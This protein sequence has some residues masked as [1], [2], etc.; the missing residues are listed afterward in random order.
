MADAVNEERTKFERSPS[1]PFI[2]LRKAVQRAQAFFDSHRKEPT[3]LTALASTWAYSPSSSGLLQTIAAMK[4]FGLLEDSGSGVDRKLQI[5]DLARTI[6]ADLRPG[7][8]EGA[9]AEAAQKPKIIAEYLPKWVPNRP[10]D[11]HCVS[12]LVF[13][14][15]FAE[16]GAKAFLKVFDDT[17]AYARLGESDIKVDVDIPSG[18]VNDEADAKPDANRNDEKQVDRWKPLVT[19]AAVKNAGETPL[20]E[21]L[22]VVTTG[23]Q[24]TI[25]AALVSPKEVDKLIRILQANRELLD[26]DPDEA[27]STA[28]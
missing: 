16:I 11:A 6:L 19:P 1:F 2:S 7:A 14:R 28:Q 3:R 15:G 20:S 27:D 4:Q 26:D 9:I 24:L 18:D 25:S 22:Q 13:D 8:K 23:N 12:E 21:R 17:I 10:S 5:S